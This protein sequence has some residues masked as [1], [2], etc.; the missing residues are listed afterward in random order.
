M[1]VPKLSLCI[2][3]MDRWD[4]Y[5]KD[6][7]AHYIDNPYIDEIVISDENGNDVVEIMNAYPDNPKFTLHINESQYGA[8]LNKNKA[9]SLARNEWVALIDSDNLAPTKEYFGA[10]EAYIGE[11]MVDPSMVYCP[12]KSIIAD[13]FH[14]LN[15]TNYA[16]FCLNRKNFKTVRNNATI[17]TVTNTGNFIV[18]KKAYLDAHD[19]QYADIMKR[20]NAWECKLKTALMLRNGLNFIIIGNMQWYHGKHDNSLYMQTMHEIDD[21]RAPIQAIYDSFCE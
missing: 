10:W 13:R 9:V 19:E 21:V 7:I 14:N 2:P 5:L 18:N 17:D 16:G 20:N 3:T 15:Y 1:P 6:S 8:H 4:T 11:G 12:G